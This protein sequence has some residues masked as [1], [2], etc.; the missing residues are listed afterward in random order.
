MKDNGLGNPA[1]DSLQKSDEQ[2]IDL[3]WQRNEEAVQ[4][5]DKKYGNYLSA[6]AFNILADRED[7]QEVLNDTYYK[8]WCSMPDKRPENLKAF[9]TRIIRTTAIDLF[10]GRHRQKRIMSE[11][12]VSLDELSETLSSH[13]TLEQTVDA[14]LLAESI[15]RFLHTLSDEECACFTGRYYYADPLREIARYLGC[16]ESKVKSMLYRIRNRL[17]TWLEKEGWQL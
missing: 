9:L 14:G 6:I 8:A 5:T 1:K 13:E 10:R 4:E 11:Y 3:Y 2:I 17:K 12:V 7:G 16:S 15:N